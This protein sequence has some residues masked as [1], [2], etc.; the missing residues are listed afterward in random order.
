[1]RNIL[2]TKTEAL[3]DPLDR[4][5]D[6]GIIIQNRKSPMT[7]RAPFIQRLSRLQSSASRIFL[8]NSIRLYGFL[9]NCMFALRDS[10]PRIEVSA[11][12]EQNSTFRLG[13]IRTAS[14]ANLRP[15]IP[16][17][18]TRS[19]KRRSTCSWSCRIRIASLPSVVSIT[20]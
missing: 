4:L 8:P 1:M 9:S 13:R 16:P 11:Y 15:F 6:V 2:R 14:R 7:H 12:P 18:M 20:R 3:G 10:S 19:V 5:S 17:G